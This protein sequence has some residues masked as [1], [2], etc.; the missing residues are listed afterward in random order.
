MDAGAVIS[1]TES[2][3]HPRIF[4]P[5]LVQDPRSR[6]RPFNTRE[7]ALSLHLHH[8]PFSQL[9]R[10][11]DQ[12]T[13]KEH[14]DSIELAQDCTGRIVCR[15]GKSAPYRGLAGSG[16]WLDTLRCAVDVDV[17]ILG[18]IIEVIRRLDAMEAIERGFNW[19]KSA[20]Y[21]IEVIVWRFTEPGGIVANAGRAPWGMLKYLTP[22]L[23]DGWTELDRMRENMVDLA[24]LLRFCVAQSSTAVCIIP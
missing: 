5:R 20:I 12:P 15:K 18:R 21:A 1:Y 2:D 23:V 6:L 7:C 4:L 13:R 14:M 10:N 16:G 11:I 19:D 22:G 9:Q 24:L 17:V 3:A 8:P